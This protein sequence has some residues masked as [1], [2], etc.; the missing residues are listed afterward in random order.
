MISIKSLNPCKFNELTRFLCQEDIDKLV[1]MEELPKTS[2]SDK[3][4]IF[5][6]RQGSGIC[7]YEVYS[8]DEEL[9]E[10]DMELWAEE[11]QVRP[12]EKVTNELY[13]FKIG[14][15]R[16]NVYSIMN[17]PDFN[18]A[19]SALYENGVN[20]DDIDDFLKL[21][22][23]LGSYQIED[24]ELYHNAEKF[25]L[26]IVNSKLFTELSQ[27][28]DAVIANM[29]SNNLNS[30]AVINSF[31]IL[32]HSDES[33]KNPEEL[34]VDLKN[35]IWLFKDV[36]NKFGVNLIFSW[37]F[38]NKGYEFESMS[39]LMQYASLDN[40][41]IHIVKRNFGKFF[42]DSE[43]LDSRFNYLGK[44]SAGTLVIESGTNGDYSNSEIKAL[45]NQ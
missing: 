7:P 25:S 15:N 31:V 16:E 22:G 44:T 4:Y 12:V 30:I 43:L 27:G 14:T 26:L 39:V 17:L 2:V 23:M 18:N 6:V 19:I 45:I 36:C 33:T 37:F 3:S 11:I 21:L 20:L 42:D 5:N 40:K 10:D 9:S 8:D 38:N 28:V 29:K 13:L 41:I 32:W 1:A 34:A 35:D 24:C